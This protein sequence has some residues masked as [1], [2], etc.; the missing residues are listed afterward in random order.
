MV[1][2]HGRRGMGRGEP[3]AGRCDVHRARGWQSGTRP[4]GVRLRSGAN[5]WGGLRVSRTDAAMARCACGQGELADRGRLCRRARETVVRRN[6]ILL[7]V[8]RQHV[9]LKNSTCERQKEGYIEGNLQDCNSH[10]LVCY[11]AVLYGLSSLG[12]SAIA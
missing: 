7:D 12:L 1:A 5:G 4:S 10:E 3:L 9:P 2:R 11:C 8:R 6:P